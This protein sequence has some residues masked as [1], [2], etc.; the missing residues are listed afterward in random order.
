MAAMRARAFVSPEPALLLSR[1][2]LRNPAHALERAKKKCM[3]RRVLSRGAT[4]S[5]GKRSASERACS[6]ES[7]SMTASSCRMIA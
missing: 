5:A 4:R 7:T 2:S 6:S 1:A 3:P